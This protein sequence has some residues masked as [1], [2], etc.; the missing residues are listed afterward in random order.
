MRIETVYK[1]SKRVA[2]LERVNKES[3]RLFWLVKEGQEVKGLVYKDYGTKKAVT[4]MTL[5]NHHRKG[6][7][8][9]SNPDADINAA[10]KAVL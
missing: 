2:H 3:D 6:T 4:A 10:V 9:S 8:L 5:P 1:G 7:F